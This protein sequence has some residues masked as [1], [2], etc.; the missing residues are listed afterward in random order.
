MRRTGLL[1]L[2]VMMGCDGGPGST[3]SPLPLDERLSPGEVRAGIIQ[4]ES[5]LLSGYEAHGWLGDFKLYNDRAAFIVEGL[6]DAREFASFGGNLIDAD[7]V[8]PEGE[9]GDEAFEQL[10][11]ILDLMTIEPQSAEIL[12]DGRDGQPARLR[13]TGRHHGFLLLDSAVGG[14]LTPKPLV[15][16]QEYELAPDSDSLLVR[17]EVSSASGSPQGVSVGDLALMGD[18]GLRFLPGLGVVGEQGFSGD[19]DFYG[20]ATESGCVLYASAEGP[21]H[22]DIGIEGISPFMEK[23]GTAE[24]EGAGEPLR[25]ERRV[26]VGGGGIDACLE[27]LRVFRGQG[28]LGTLQGVVRAGAGPEPGAIVVA[29]GGG[30]PAGKDAVSQAFAGDDGSYRFR[31]PPGEYTIEARAGALPAKIAGPVTVSAG[32]SATLDVELDL[33]ARLVVHC[34]EVDPVSGEEMSPLPCA[35]SFQEGLDAPASRPTLSQY[36]TFA[37]NAAAVVRL[38]A[39]PY[40]LTA[41]HGFDYSLHRESLTLGAGEE[42]TIR[43]RLVRERNTAGYLAMDPHGHSGRSVETHFPLTDKIAGNIAAGV[44]VLVH[45]DHDCQVDSRAFLDGMARQAGADLSGRIRV[46]TGIEVSPTYAHFTAFGVPTH[47]TG[48]AFWMIPYAT[49]RDGVFEKTL[50]FPDLFA[51]ARELGAAVINVAHPIGDKGYFSHL[52]FDPPGTVPRLAD[53]PPEKWDPAFDTLEALN[54]RAVDR[55]LEHNL[56]LWVAL[57]NQGFF[58]TAVG[59]SDSHT[60]DDPPGFGR[61]LVMVGKALREAQTQEIFEALKAGHALVDGG[62]LVEIAID[63]SRPGDLLTRAGGLSLH[64]RVQAASWVPARRVEILANGQVVASRLLPEAGV[65][66]AAHPALRL[67]ED[68]PFAPVADTWYAA[69]AVSDP[70]DDLNPAF[71]GCRPVGLANAIRVDVDGDGRFTPPNP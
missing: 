33:P 4:K 49:Y 29:H 64:L 48:W 39:G 71:P 17:L 32:E 50:E 36:L 6:E 60:R 68:L 54:S 51:R 44:Q 41:S 61:T 13:I 8:R 20:V 23:T 35:L 24:P 15:I 12:A 9:A 67:E 25:V 69:V 2:V 28:P 27:K 63:Q 10:M 37:W 59:V 26:F 42:R 14:T 43:A 45:T 5:E 1:F 70:Q 47:A 30:L 40:T 38:P 18:R 21:L 16:R 46:L 7:R 19:F 62:I 31:L 65:F 11:P 66:D 58:R 53:L 52:G 22:V 3:E 34:V 56:P 55:M 57:N